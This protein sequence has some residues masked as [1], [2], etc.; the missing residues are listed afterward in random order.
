VVDRYH[1]GYNGMRFNYLRG[2]PGPWCYHC[3]SASHVKSGGCW[4]LKQAVAMKK[5]GFLEIVT[6]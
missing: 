3:N 6:L 1:E 5:L 2:G 4:T